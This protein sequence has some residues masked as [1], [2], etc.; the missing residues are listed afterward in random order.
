MVVFRPFRG[1]K[2]NPDVVGDLAKVVSPPYDL[3]TPELQESLLKRSPYNVVHL[4]AGRTWT[5]TLPV[6]TPTGTP[7]TCLKNGCGEVYCVGSKNLVSICPSTSSDSREN[8]KPDR[9]YRMH[10]PG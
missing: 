7:P 10:R 1:W 4:E 8:Q 5:G 3:I 6:E 2:Y 9:H